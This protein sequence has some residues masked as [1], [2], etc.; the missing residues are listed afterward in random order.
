MNVKGI[1]LLILFALEFCGCRS[2]TWDSEG[3]FDVQFGKDRDETYETVKDLQ[4][5]QYEKKYRK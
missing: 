3:G 2:M 5:E 4:Q 1:V